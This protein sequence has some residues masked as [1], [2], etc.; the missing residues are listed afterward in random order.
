VLL[1]A[2][3]AELSGSAWAW[4]Q[5]HR[6][7]RLP[8]L[9]LELHT[10]VAGVVRDLVIGNMVDGL[11]DVSTGGLGVALTEMA[12]GSGVGYQAAR[13]PDHAALFSES[14]SR[15]VVCVAPDKLQTVLAV[16][17][18]AGVL[19]ARIGL[20]SGDRCAVKDLYDLPL[21]EVTTT[22]RHRL[23]DAL[24]AGTAQG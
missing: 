8:G 9:D 5:G 6:T 19:T 3:E 22:W 11:H 18:A 24:G 2:T 1:G 21:D 12:V 4:A 16:A 14:P 10:R 15:V 7:G 17:E 23:P 20:A 13:I